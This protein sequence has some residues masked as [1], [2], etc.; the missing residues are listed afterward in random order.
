MLSNTM[1]VI[2]FDVRYSISAEA[3]RRRIV[4]KGM[5]SAE[6]MGSS[7]KLNV[8][9]PP[10]SVVMPGSSPPDSNYRLITGRHAR[11]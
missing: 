3:C 1:N 6:P 4:L 10:L 9:S 2:E 5:F 8:P 11:N 7:D